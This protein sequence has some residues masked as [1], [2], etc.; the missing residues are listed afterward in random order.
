MWHRFISICFLLT[1]LTFASSK[2]PHRLKSRDDHGAVSNLNIS[3]N[4]GNYSSNICPIQSLNFGIQRNKFNSDVERQKYLAIAI[5]SSFT[6]IR[7]THD[8]NDSDE[9]ELDEADNHSD[10]IQVIF[11]IPYTMTNESILN[12]TVFITDAA[13]NQLI[14]TLMHICINNSSFII[15]YLT[16]KPLPHNICLYILLNITSLKELYLC[17]TINNNFSSD[18]SASGDGH[19]V[20]PS[21][22]FIVLLCMLIVLMMITIYVI[23]TARKKSLMNRITEHLFRNKAAA[24]ASKRNIINPEMTN[25]AQLN[26]LITSPI[27]GQV[28]AANNL[29]SI[30]TDRR[31]TNHNLINIKEFTKRLS[32]TNNNA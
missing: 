2:S 30:H 20:G 16:S 18:H 11:T 23:Q 21:G 29:T 15:N 17:R 31:F 1:N 24:R 8:Y 10:S 3:S 4:S 27:E 12:E 5:T 9:D 28:L 13:G 26:N 22:L 14:A 25:E 19:A 7:A 32:I 6:R